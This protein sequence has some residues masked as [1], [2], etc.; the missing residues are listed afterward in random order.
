MSADYLPR[1]ASELHY[2]LTVTDAEP[3]MQ[4]RADALAHLHGLGR[5]LPD[6]TADAQARQQWHAFKAEQTPR[7]QAPKPPA[8]L[9][10]EPKKPEPPAPAAPAVATPA[11]RRFEPTADQLRRS[12][13]SGRLTPAA[14]VRITEQLQ[15][16]EGTKDHT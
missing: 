2:L 16:M 5:T 3:R 1:N 9:Y 6:T 7:P 15:R 10:L 4:Q 12:L 14:R 13:A 11:S 8:F